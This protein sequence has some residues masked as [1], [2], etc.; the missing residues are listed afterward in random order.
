MHPVPKPDFH[1]LQDAQAEVT[2]SRG[3]SSEEMCS[4]IS[5]VFKV[6]FDGLEPYTWQLDVSEAL[7]LGLDCIAI[8]G[9]GA[10]KAM[11]FI[12]PLLVDPKTEKMVI[13]ISPLN[14]LG[15]DQV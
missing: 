10:G 5:S 11:P 6:A 2:R 14:A 13:V 3:Y 15:H 7:L 1:I 12:V 8:A 4:K 9:T